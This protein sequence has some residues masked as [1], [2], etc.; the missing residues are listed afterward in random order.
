MGKRWSQTQS[1]ETTP[2][3]SWL[4]KVEVGGHQSGRWK[5]LVFVFSDDGNKVSREW[6]ESAGCRTLGASTGAS[7]AA[8]R[9]LQ[10]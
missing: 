6:M 3:S 4:R 9:Q 10:R 2:L 8:L 1:N 7:V 5:M